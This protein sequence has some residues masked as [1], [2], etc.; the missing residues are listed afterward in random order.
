MKAISENKYKSLKNG[1]SG[2]MR[3]KNDSEFVE[4]C[5]DSCIDALDELIIVY[6]DCSDDTPELV[7]KKKQEYPSKIKVYEY[8]HKV[9]SVNLSKEEYEYALHLSEDSPN[10]LCNYYNFALS[11]V[12]Y[13]Y[14]IKIDADQIYFSGQLKKWCDVCREDDFSIGFLN[15]FIGFLFNLYFVFFK[16]LCFKRMKSYS[17]MPSWLV[18]L[19]YPYYIDYAK[20]QFQKGH[21]ALSLSG[22]NVAKENDS[23]FVSLGK[24][25]EIINILPPFNGDGDHLLFRVSP[26]TYYVKYDMPYYNLLTT[27]RYS[28]IEWFHQPYKILPVGFSW[29]HV[30][31]MRKKNM[32]KVLQVKSKCPASFVEL[33]HFV[34]MQYSDILSKSDK[35]MFVARHRALFMFIFKANVEIVKQNCSLLQ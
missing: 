30:N 7:R 5:I 35:E 23:W 12:T 26:Q 6:N 2:I 27:G 19:S 1:V 29:F 4:T 17:L 15:Y 20:K 10:L 21:V 11:K 22:V 3:V 18:R 32:A 24:H 14:A 13:K 9:Y 31:A 33:H 34:D 28:L 25:H 16:Y 8:K